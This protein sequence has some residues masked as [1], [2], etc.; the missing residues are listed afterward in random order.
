MKRL[1][2]CLAGLVLLFGGFEQAVMFL[3]QG[4]SI[5]SAA[6]YDLAADW[7]NAANPN[8]V[9][10]Y[11]EGTNA[12]PSVADWTPLGSPVVQPAW[13]PSSAGGNFLPAWFKSTANNP[14]DVD[15]H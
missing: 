3:P 15:V 11:R 2:S 8:G 1:L 12:L 6:T 7:S 10:T 14:S 13:A 5:A 4:V 9:W